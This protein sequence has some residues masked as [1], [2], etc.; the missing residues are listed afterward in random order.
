VDIIASPMMTGLPCAAVRP[1]AAPSEDEESS[2]E[3]VFRQLPFA[4]RCQPVDPG[5]EIDRLAGEEN[6][7]LRNQ[8]DHRGFKLAGNQ[9]RAGW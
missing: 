4:K 7:K 9:R 5:A 8:L 6:P 2:R 1:S 3:R